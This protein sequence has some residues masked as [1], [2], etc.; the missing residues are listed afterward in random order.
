MGSGDVGKG[1]RAAERGPRE[2]I[3]TRHA[4]VP[5]ATYPSTYVTG[6]RNVPVCKSLTPYWTGAGLQ[7]H[8]PSIWRQAVLRCTGPAIGGGL[9][10]VISIPLLGKPGLLFSLRL[11][12]YEPRS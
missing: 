8:G 6:A 10:A 3:C 9:G 5:G 4:S 2:E 12:G 1:G 11:L 7:W